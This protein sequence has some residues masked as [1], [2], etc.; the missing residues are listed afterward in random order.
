FDK[1]SAIALKE[2]KKLFKKLAKV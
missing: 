2:D 1:A